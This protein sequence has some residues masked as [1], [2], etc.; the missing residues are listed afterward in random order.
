MVRSFVVV[1][2]LSLLLVLFVVVRC[3]S[4][5]VVVRRSQVKEDP[6]DD[7]T[8]DGPA[9]GAVDG[10]AMIPMDNGPADGNASADGDGGGGT[11][12]RRYHVANF[13]FAYVATPFVVS[14]WVIF[15]SAAKIGLQFP[16]ATYSL[17]FFRW[18]I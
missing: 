9:A 15:A 5:S 18:F 16:L 2:P 6:T 14:L 7:G 4:S 8:T 13:D 10:P 11:E 12:G 17:R 1:A 3:S